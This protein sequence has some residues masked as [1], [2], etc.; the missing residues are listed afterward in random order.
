MKHLVVPV[1]ALALVTSVHADRQAAVAR[2]LENAYWDVVEHMEPVVEEA[3]AA[4]ALRA[5]ARKVEHHIEVW[6]T[7]DRGL[8]ADR[9]PTLLPEVLVPHRGSPSLEQAGA[10]AFL[11][12]AP[13]ALQDAVNGE[14]RSRYSS[15]GMGFA[16]FIRPWPDHT[17]AQLRVRPLRT[18]A[19]VSLDVMTLLQQAAGRR[20]ELAE[21]VLAAERYQP[22]V[23][24]RK[25]ATNT[26]QNEAE[27]E[28]IERTYDQ[29]QERYLT[30]LEGVRSAAFL[31]AQGILARH[32]VYGR[33]QVDAGRGSVGEF[34]LGSSRNVSF[35]AFPE[36]GPVTAP[37]G[38]GDGE[39]G[40]GDLAGGGAGATGTG[41]GESGPLEI[42]GREV[43]A[44]L[45]ATVKA[46]IE[47]RGEVAY[48]IGQAELYDE[49]EEEEDEEES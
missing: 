42:D 33:R 10:A 23:Q 39:P 2:A 24:E 37:T 15:G 34:F 30:I 46:A 47:Y 32:I 28:A 38:T 11:E 1:L 8:D 21:A 20:E 35:V 29:A 17:M 44:L 25:W 41:S 45:P 18:G 43:L 36:A 6:N 19:G 5:R 27:W 13:E 4:A 40:F 48:E 22:E 12:A 3:A 31:Q 7:R 9:I 49:E 16:P 14:L 26:W